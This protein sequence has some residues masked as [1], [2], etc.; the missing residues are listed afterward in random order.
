M[1]SKLLCIAAACALSACGVLKMSS[2]RDD[3]MSDRAA[4]LTVVQATVWGVL[5]GATATPVVLEVSGNSH[6]PYAQRLKL[7]DEVYLGP[8]PHSLGV[9]VAG[10]PRGPALEGLE[11]AICLNMIAEPRTHYVL[12]ARVES[13]N[14]VLD[15]MKRD[16]ASEIRLASLPVQVREPLNEPICPRGTDS[17]TS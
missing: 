6:W 14:F 16:G 9:L 3:A 7:D 15:L 5:S 17:T 8:G 1:P 11:G 13:G 10:H 12:Q 2:P 4:R